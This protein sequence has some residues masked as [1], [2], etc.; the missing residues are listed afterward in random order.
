LSV[1]TQFVVHALG[2][3]PRFV[4]RRTVAP[5]VVRLLPA[6]SFACTVITEV[7]VPFAVIDAR[8]ALIVDV[9]AEIVPGVTENVDVPGVSAI[10]EALIV[11]EP[12]VW[13]V[14]SSVATPPDAVALP[15]PVTEPGPALSANVTDVVLSVVIVFPAES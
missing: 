11:T 2:N 6:A 10:A 9:T 5:P 14:T 8:L 12:A 15:R 1:G 4:E 3:V 13:P 7:L